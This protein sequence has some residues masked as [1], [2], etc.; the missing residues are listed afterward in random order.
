MCGI[1]GWV[2]FERDL[3]TE[4]PILDAMTATMASGPGRPRHLDDGPAALGHRR[5]AIIDLPGGR[6]PM[7]VDA[8]AATRDGVL[9]RGRTTTANCASNCRAR[10][11]VRH[12]LRH[13][14]RAARIPGVGRRVAERLNGMYAFAMWDAPREKLVMVRDR[15]GIK[16][17]YYYPTPD[18]VLFGSEPKAI[19]ANPLARRTVTLDGLREL[20]AFVRTPGH[21][22]WRRH[23]R[24]RA[25]H[26]R[27]RRPRR[28]ARAHG[29]GRWRPAPHTDDLATSIAT[30]ASCSTTSCAASWSPTC[31]AARCCPAAWTPPP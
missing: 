28:S 10:A 16:P 20:F 25:R 31:R 3:R 23:A 9:R 2:A 27:H 19:L 18:G 11:P 4:R 29:T 22:V 24:G 1:T 5:L 6:Q 13:R 15:M 8:P 12:R 17:L 21:A 7:S 30:S 26:G 14:G